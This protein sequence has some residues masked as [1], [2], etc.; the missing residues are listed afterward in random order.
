MVPGASGVYWDHLCR[1]RGGYGGGGAGGRGL[2]FGVGGRC[3][4]GPDG[5]AVEP[6]ELRYGFGGVGVGGGDDA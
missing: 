5:V 1:R 6:F 3:G 4:A 2:P